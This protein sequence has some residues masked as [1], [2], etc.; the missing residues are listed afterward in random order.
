MNYFLGA[1]IMRAL[2]EIVLRKNWPLM[3]SRVLKFAIVIEKR[4]GWLNVA[5]F[6]LLRQQI[7]FNFLKKQL[8]L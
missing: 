3:A 1:R 6:H 2:F 8:F 7:D 4:V 5:F